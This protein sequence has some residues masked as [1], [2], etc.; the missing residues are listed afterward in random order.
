MRAR[1]NRL[2]SRSRVTAS[3]PRLTGVRPQ[4]RPPGR[5]DAAWIR[6]CSSL[7][8]GLGSGWGGT[9]EVGRGPTPAASVLQTAH[10]VNMSRSIRARVLDLFYT[11]KAVP[12]R[13]LG[14]E[15]PDARQLGIRPDRKARCLQ[16]GPNGV[17]VVRAQGG[18]ATAGHDRIL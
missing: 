8:L 16:P 1:T 4:L 15:A 18:M 11:F 14:E 5:R 12:E 2:K 10:G 13:V 7:C 17:Q 6:E 9:I 3:P